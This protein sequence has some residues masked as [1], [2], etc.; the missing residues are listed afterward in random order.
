M[1]KGGPIMLSISNVGA[2][3][4][5]SYYDK[6]GYYARMEDKDNIWFG[7]LKED[8]GLSEALQKNDFNKLVQERKE[9]AGFDLCFSAPKSVSIAMCMDDEIRRDMLEAH[10]K[11]VETILARIEKNEIGAR[12]TN[13]KVTKH[14]KTGNMICGRFNHYVSRA[15]DPQLHTHAVIL[16]KTKYNGKYY[17]VDNEPLYKNKIFYGQLYRNTL[18]KEL[19]QKGYEVKTTNREKGFFELAGIK[20]KSIEHFSSRREE[21]MKQLKEWGASSPQSAE[22]AALLTRQAKEHRDIG[23]LME[24]WKETLTQLNEKCV[25]KAAEPIVPTKEQYDAELERAVK[26]LSNR[27]FAFKERDYEKFALAHGVGVGMAEDQ[28]KDYF[29]EQQGKE[30]LYLGKRQDNKKDL[31]VYF[32]TQKNYEIEQEIFQRLSQAK[33]KLEGI[34]RGKVKDYLDKNAMDQEGNLVL[35]KQQRDAVIFVTTNKDQYSAVQGLAG[36]GKTRMLNVARQVFESNDYEVKGVCFAGKAAEGLQKD[37]GI[38]STTIH[39]FLNRLERENGHMDTETDFKEKNE[40]NVSGLK[41]GDKK[42]VWIVDEAGMV[43]NSTMRS[44]MQAADARKAKIVFV[45]DKNQLLPI[46]VGNSF[47]HSVNKSQIATVTIDEIQRQKQKDLLQSVKEAVLGSIF[48]SLEILDKNKDVQQIANRKDRMKEIVKEYVNLSQVERKKTIILTADNQD[49]NLLNTNIRKELKKTGQLAPGHVAKIEDSRGYISKREF[50]VD[51]KVIFLRNDNQLGVKNGQTGFIQEIKQNNLVID[52]N[53]RKMEIDLLQYN[54][55]DHGYAMTTHKAQGITEDRALIHID[56][57]QKQLNSRNSYYV[58][59]SRA[60]HQ[61]KIFTDARDK[62][63]KQ[64]QEFAKKLTSDDFLIPQK[65]TDLESGKKTEKINSSTFS[66]DNLK[67]M[68]TDIMHQRANLKLETI[69]R[70]SSDEL[71]KNISNSSDN[72]V[73]GRSRSLLR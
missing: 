32:G 8:L 30:I 48:K 47:A 42:E 4:A 46:A 43:G 72:K 45:G 62:I 11:A 55:I 53:G 3:Q 59:I 49:R 5:G 37:S 7:S 50:S 17:A 51:D 54:K 57:A 33:N 41:P 18:A 13:D 40:W 69:A 16:N 60:R 10:N 23:K 36:T 22:K 39:S 35:S 68:Y 24:S 15:S 64:V 6:D 27:I 58:D 25:E 34:E 67:L 1:F 56:S 44:L 2:K 70:T 29:Q 38:A 20:E 14:I 9:R 66:A 63:E 12:V 61:V 19:M 28:V 73:K 31:S 65:A 26:H 71:I 21:I 52:T